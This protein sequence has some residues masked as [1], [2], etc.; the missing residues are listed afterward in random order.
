VIDFLQ[1]TVKIRMTIQFH[2]IMQGRSILCRDPPALVRPLHFDDVR[3]LREV[4]VQ[5]SL[6]PGGLSLTVG[7][8]YGCVIGTL[9][10]SPTENVTLCF[11]D[12]DGLAANEIVE[13]PACPS[14]D[15]GFITAAARFAVGVDGLTADVGA[16]AAGFAAGV[17]VVAVG[18][19]AGVAVIGFAAGDGV[20]VVG[21]AAGAIVV[22]AGWERG[23]AEIV[24]EVSLRRIKKSDLFSI[25]G[26][27]VSTVTFCGTAK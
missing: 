27:V 1:K 17:G 18:L 8:W 16:G 23:D 13:G 6:L 3:D 2:F 14:V 21:L 26:D 24:L 20:G 11:C 4:P 22:V 10:V 19:D 12:V 9:G 15:G 25:S 7:G 5:L